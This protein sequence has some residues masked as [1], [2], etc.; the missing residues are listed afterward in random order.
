ME[1]KKKETFTI[2]TVLTYE[3]NKMLKQAMTDLDADSKKEAIN[4]V[5]RHY[6]KNRKK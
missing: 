2:Q 4:R 6:Y 5:I 3:E 1:E